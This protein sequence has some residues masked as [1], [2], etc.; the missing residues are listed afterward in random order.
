MTEP[1]EPTPPEVSPPSDP[2]VK[3]P[4]TPTQDR[5]ATAALP[6]SYTAII[7]VLLVVAAIGSGLAIGTITRPRPTPVVVV[8]TPTAAPTRVPLPTTDPAV[9]R[10]TFSG[11]CSTDQAIWVVT[12]GGGLIRYD[13]QDWVQVDGTL[14]TLVHASCDQFMLYAVGPVGAVLIVDDRARSIDA[15]DVTIDHLFG[16]Q[17]LPSGAVVA[18]QQGA[19]LL[20][21]GG[22]WQPYAV[23]IEE[24]L[25]AVILFGPLSG[26]TVGA[27][28][29][30]YHLET[31][32]WRAVAT[33]TTQ[34]L[35][36][37][38]AT[39]PTN[40]VAVG[41]AGTVAHF[42]D[43]WSLIPS[44]ADV[45][46]RDVIVAPDLWIVGDAGTV[47]TSDGGGLRR[48]DVGTKCDLKAVF[49]RA[50]EIWM[51]GSVGANGGVLRLRSGAVAERWGAC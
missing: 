39:G 1:A 9:F 17:A 16:V 41:D 29:V 46:L 36:G 21:D 42:D 28:G 51:I 23:G 38:A 25:S 24:D 12:D 37:L 13:G 40:V 26:W 15:F 44:G 10:Q 7:A 48:V 33:G 11:G 18:G 4:L 2:T 34:T 5:Q 19:I 22:T 6:L 49:S 45:A 31:A 35:R 14:R 3:P 8:P 27:G 43:H 20:L 30:S 47:L 32:G 50:G